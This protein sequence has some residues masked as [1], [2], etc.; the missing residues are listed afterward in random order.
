MAVHEEKVEPARIV[1]VDESI[2][3]AN[4]GSRSRSYARNIRDI[5]EAHL[6][7]V[8]V[9]RR[10]VIAEVTYDD[11]RTSR[12]HVIAK[13]HT[14]VGLFDA[15]LAD[16]Y[17]CGKGDVGKV[18]VPIVLVEIVFLAVVGDEK[19]EMTIGVEIRPNGSQTKVILRVVNAGFL[20]YVRKCSVAIVVVEIVG[21]TLEPPRAALDIDST[22][23]TRLT[24]SGNWKIA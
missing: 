19:I 21:R 6:P 22:V 20:R 1:N 9:Y 18:A 2:S 17:A 10:V 4:I 24:A 11:R 7:V 13:G 23:L 14:H 15:V 16:G 5:G 12:V 3:P 8:A